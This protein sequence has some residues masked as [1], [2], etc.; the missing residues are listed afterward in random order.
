MAYPGVWESAARFQHGQLFAILY[1]AASTYA[2]SERINKQRTKRKVLGDPD[3]SK[4]FGYRAHREI[5]VS[6]TQHG[7]E[8]QLARPIPKLSKWRNKSR[9][10]YRTY[11][12][13]NRR[14]I[15]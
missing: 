3:D 14:Q 2:K 5:R 13:R 10:L 4:S 9:T 12:A 15:Q 1:L 6:T 7:E 8:Y 11:N